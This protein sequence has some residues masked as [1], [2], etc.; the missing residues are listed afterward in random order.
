VTNTKSDHE[1]LKS[2][3]TM[4]R[5]LLRTVGSLEDYTTLLVREIARARSQAE[6]IR[7]DGDT[8]RP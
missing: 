2:V 3:D 4:I 5:V 1:P 6:E 7:D 8:K